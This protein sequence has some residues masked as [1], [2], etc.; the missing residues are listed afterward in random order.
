MSGLPA[1]AMVTLKLC[2]GPVSDSLVPR[3]SPSFLSH[4]K[5]GKAGWPGNKAKWMV[6]CANQQHIKLAHKMRLGFE[7]VSYSLFFY[8][9]L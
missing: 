1:L 4:C 7:E 8:C 5:H 6:L 3:P 2:S 9:G